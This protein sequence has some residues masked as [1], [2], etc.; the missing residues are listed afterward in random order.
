MSTTTTT[1]TIEVFYHPHAR[2]R[3]RWYAE[4]IDTRTGVVVA[5]APFAADPSEAAAK[6][7]ALLADLGGPSAVAQTPAV[8]R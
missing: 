4:I 3:A 6:A 7:R 5:R 2:G 1:T 8:V